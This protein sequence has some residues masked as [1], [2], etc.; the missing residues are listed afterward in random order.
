[1]DK[2]KPIIKFKNVNKEYDGGLMGLD[3]VTL[4][5]AP[6][7]FVFLIG[8]SG[9]GKTTLMKHIVKEE[10]PTSG[11]IHI[12]GEDLSTIKSNKIPYLRRKIGFI[13]QDFKLMDS[14]TTAENIALSLLVA[15]KA[16]DEINE[17]VARLI[18]LVGL[19]GKEDKFPTHLSGGE[20]QRLSI[21]RALAHEPK[22]LLADEPTGNLDRTST[23]VVVDLIKKINDW[24]TTIIFGTHDLE[25]VKA[26]KKRVV[27]IEKG[28]IIKDEDY[29][30]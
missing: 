6:G 12:D 23:W 29:L 19:S 20:K 21:A 11:E 30:S 8:S 28:K 17:V 22:I 9:A 3:N 7:E 2:N 25:L 5:I 16:Q 15:G 10:V 27:Q 14:K 18:E 4:E 26:L 1:M 24:G 13:Y